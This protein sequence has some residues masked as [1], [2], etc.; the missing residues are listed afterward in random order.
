MF[1]CRAGTRQII[2]VRP[3]VTVLA[4]CRCYGQMMSPGMLR[5]LYVNTPTNCLFRAVKSVGGLHTAVSMVIL[6]SW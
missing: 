5:D 6:E 4:Y 1:F 3:G 2:V